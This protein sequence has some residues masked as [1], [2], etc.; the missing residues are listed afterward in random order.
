MKYDI[1]EN[2]YRA[3]NVANLSWVIPFRKF[4]LGWN[5]NWQEGYRVEAPTGTSGWSNHVRER[6]THTL[7]FGWEIRRNTTFYVTARNI[8][9]QD[10]GEYRGRSDFRTR[11]V[12]TGAVWTT[13]VRAS[14]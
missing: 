11:W 3:S 12:Q 5:S 9:N 2:F 10:G 14:F 6:F 7:D 8:F 13:G 1:Y 4:R